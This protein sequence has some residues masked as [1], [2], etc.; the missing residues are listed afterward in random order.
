[1][2]VISEVVRADLVR[3]VRAPGKLVPAELRWVAATS[4][5]RVEHIILDPGD[6]VTQD[7]VVMTLSNPDLAEAL[8]SARLELNVLEAEYKALEQRLQNNRLNQES[9]IADVQSQYELADFRLNANQELSKDRAVSEISLEESV[10]QEK[11]LQIKY[12][13]EQRKLT[14]LIS[15]HEAELAAKRARVDQS[16]RALQLQ[17]KLFDELQVRAEFPGHLQDIPVEQGQQLVKGTI[18]ARVADNE[19]LKTELRVQESQ[20]K[21][22]Q[23]G[24]SVVISAG[25]NNTRGTVRRVEPEVQEGVV[26]VEVFFD[27]EPLAGGRF[28]LRVDGVI[29]LERLDKVLKIKRPVFSQENAALN[30]FVLD[31]GGDTASR[32]L[33]RIGKTSTNEIEIIDGLAEGEQVIVS[34]TSQFNQLEQFTLR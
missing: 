24:Q 11:A 18:L 27:D 21:D 13:I 25:G 9:I 7:S 17:Q 5:A 10:L 19:N 8:D 3:E 4:N 31:P 32:R 29:Q 12:D 16:A 34:D 15:L 33:V 23:P 1:N 2:L 20:V 28:D 22:I 26:I 30:L 14:S 6:A